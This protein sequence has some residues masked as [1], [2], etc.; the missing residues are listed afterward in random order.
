MRIDATVK[1]YII[2]KEGKATEA[3]TKFSANEKVRV[4]KH[5]TSLSIMLG[6]SHVMNG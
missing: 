5:A 4:V 2:V 1:H 6:Y 3:L